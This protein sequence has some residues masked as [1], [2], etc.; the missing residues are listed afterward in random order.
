MHA[1]GFDRVSPR[2]AKHGD[3]LCE[4][5]SNGVLYCERGTAHILRKLMKQGIS[6]VAKLHELFGDAVPIFDM[7]FLSDLD[8]FVEVDPDAA[9]Q[10]VLHLVHG[11][12]QN[13][14]N[15]KGG[16]LMKHLISALP[17]SLN[18]LVEICN[19][20]GPD[21][22]CT[23]LENGGLECVSN[24]TTVCPS[25][26]AMLLLSIIRKSVVSDDVV[27][28]ICQVLAATCDP[29]AQKCVLEI[30]AS[31][32]LDDVVSFVCGMFPLRNEDCFISALNLLASRGVTGSSFSRVMTAIQECLPT[33]DERLIHAICNFFEAVVAQEEMKE[34]I[35]QEEFLRMVVDWI[36]ED[37]PFGV[38]EMAVLLLC[39]IAKAA[40]NKDDE[41]VM[42]N[43][44]VIDCILSLLETDTSHRLEL[45]Q[46]VEVFLSFFNDTALPESMAMSLLSAQE[47]FESMVFDEDKLV[48]AFS[49]QIMEIISNCTLL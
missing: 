38:K 48:S 37:Y 34:F 46:G 14:W 40:Q 42:M 9:I 18:A 16:R 4:D 10:I 26:A 17:D 1:G 35:F 25:S 32:D 15:F 44:P 47:L 20:S 49:K 39:Q 31:L 22:L 27:F 19:A 13:L 45:L 41:R 29:E 28:K 11:P 36:T 8:A 21:L 7:K 30:L 24:L 2:A 3:M 12:P 5:V 6:P 43:L 33:K 23:F